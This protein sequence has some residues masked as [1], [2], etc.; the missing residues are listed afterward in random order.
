M[1]QR[2][3]A[4]DHVKMMIYRIRSAGHPR[5]ANPIRVERHVLTIQNSQ[6][7]QKKRRQ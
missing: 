1:C 4:R 5:Q 2:R 3:R 7:T 6:F